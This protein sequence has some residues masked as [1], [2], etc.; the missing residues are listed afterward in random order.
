LAVALCH[1]IDHL[2]GTLYID[3]V[4]AYIED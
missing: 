4:I 1:E 3:N 2:S